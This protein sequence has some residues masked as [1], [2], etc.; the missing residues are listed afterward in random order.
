MCVIWFLPNQ[1]RCGEEY[2]LV[3]DYM[4][5]RADSTL[6]NKRTHYHAYYLHLQQLSDSGENKTPPT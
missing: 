1:Q 3:K 5:L 6:I 2:L 4:A